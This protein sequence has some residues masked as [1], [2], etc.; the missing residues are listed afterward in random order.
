[1][2]ELK[3]RRCVNGIMEIAVP[4]SRTDLRTIGDVCMAIE[5][6]LFPAKNHTA[7]PVIEAVTA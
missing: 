5:E 2:K 4:V 7:E 3:I 6:E 1:M